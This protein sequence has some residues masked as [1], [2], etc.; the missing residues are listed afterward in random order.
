M[1]KKLEKFT[2]KSFKEYTGP[3]EEFKH[4]NIVF[5]Y[6]GR[7]KS[8]LAKGIIEKFGENKKENYRFFDNNY[9][10]NNLLLQ[11]SVNPKI[12]GVIAN[13]G[14]KD[15][16]IETK[17]N[18][19]KAEIMDTNKK[20]ENI[21]KLKKEIIEEINRIY[22]R[23]KGKI[24]INKKQFFKNS[25]NVIEL[26]NDDIKAAK[27]IENNETELLNIQGGD[28]LK[29]QKEKIETIIIRP[30]NIIVDTRI[31]EIKKIFIKE[32]DDIEIPS[33]KIVEWIETGLSIHKE[34]D[35][36]KFCNGTLK[37]NLIK[38]NLDI[39]KSNEKQQAMGI[40][41]KFKT[42]IDVLN[43][44]VSEMIEGKNNII[45]NL[46]KDTIEFFDNIESN[47]NLL[48]SYKKTIEKKI[49]NI[50]LSI[51]F[52]DEK[53]K[54]IL[55]SIKNSYEA[56]NKIKE[57]QLEILNNKENKLNILIKGAIGLEIRNNTF[58]KT[59]QEMIFQE[60]KSLE[61]IE[62]KNEK[63]KNQIK[64]LENSKANTKDFADHISEI[65]NMLEVNLK[66]E[67]LNN[68]YIIKH[69]ITNEEL[70]L[71]EISEGEKNLL[72]L[73]YFY[74]EL[75]ED[76]EQKKLKSSIELIVVDD[77]ISSVDDINK[78]YI[79]ELIKKIC[80]L[81]DIQLFIFT[82][83]WEDFCYI[84]YNKLDKQD[85][86]YRF[87]EIKKD[88][89]G[90]KIV[91]TKI[92]ETPYQHN[93]KEIYEFSK[94]DSVSDMT[95]CEIYHYPNIMRKILEE[96]LSF[97]VKKNNPTYNNINNIKTVLCGNSCKINDDIAIRTLLNVCNIL[98]HK[99]S[100]NPDEILKSAKF[101]MNKIKEVDKLHFDTMKE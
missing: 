86:P 93:F 67:V 18:S 25:D 40:L 97:K 3:N 49:E 43:S 22:E 60:K 68:D 99:S 64:E 31:D 89:N 4:K 75:F 10:N 19:L 52:E 47:I 79:L 98:S 63:N 96:F 36:C 73:L 11:E 76:K 14:E 38:N 59:N 69:S 66:L 54:K 34:G 37:L 83:V 44:Q 35:K 74:Y 90:S 28:Y 27:K 61:E 41:M 78:M 95:D 5:G 101:L 51:E 58:I 7:G 30:L 91:N 88:S 70:K 45:S 21:K 20:E 92:N 9:I 39:Y 46:G 23:R 56:I 53:L 2:K 57:E 84:C 12:K 50:N 16:D 72:S 82:H 15:V 13:F 48:D 65:L 85:T 26:Y 29:E 17:I 77:P 62:N 71:N 8:S 100:R 42:E 33:S 81:K 1:L 87:Y 6:N 80:E 32:F 94:K 24:L 55:N